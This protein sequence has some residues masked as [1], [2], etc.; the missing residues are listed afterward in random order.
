MFCPECGHQYDGEVNYCTDCGAKIATQSPTSQR[1]REH[2]TTSSID[3]A[4]IRDE[5]SQTAT[6]TSTKISNPKANFGWLFFGSLFISLLAVFVGI[7]S[8]FRVPSSLIGEW[9]HPNGNR[10]KI[11]RWSGEIKQGRQTVQGLPKI[12]CE[13]MSNKR[14]QFCTL[15]LSGRYEISFEENNSNTL[16]VRPAWVFSSSQKSVY[17][18]NHE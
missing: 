11:S 8:I 15:T 14:A 16:V 4:A 7:E 10:I 17:T 13:K 5:S 6:P 18:K 3:H 9:S 2:S 12:E 1:V